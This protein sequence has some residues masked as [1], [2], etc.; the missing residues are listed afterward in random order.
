MMI[1][2]IPGADI[3]NQILIPFW[4]TEIIYYYS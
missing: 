2:L 3:D 1:N 4:R